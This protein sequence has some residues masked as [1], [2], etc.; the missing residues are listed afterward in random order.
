MHSPGFIAGVLGAGMV[1]LSG[2]SS[3]TVSSSG[4]MTE[5]AAAFASPPDTTR[6]KV[7]WFHGETET[8]RAGITADLEAY[9][10][11]GIGGVVYY[12]QVHNSSTPDAFEALSPDWWEMLLFSAQ[13]AERLGLTFECHVSNGYVAGGPW[14]TP[15]KGMQRLAA[16]D[17]VL[18]GGSRVEVTLPRPASTYYKDVAVLAFPSTGIWQEESRR[19]MPLI[20]SNIPSF[21]AEAVFVPGKKLVSIPVQEAGKSVYLTLD[22]GHA[23]TAR[24][25]TYQTSPRGKA[26]TSA[27]NVPGPPGETFVGTGYQELPPLGQ[28]EVSDDGIHYRPVCDI[29]PIY[30]AHLSWRQ[31]TVA[32]PTVTARYFRLNLHDWQ[33]PGIS[34]GLQL[35][36]VTLSVRACVDLWEEKAGLYSEYVAP[37][38]TPSY[39]TSEVIDPSSLVDLTSCLDAEGV[40]HWDAPA[41]EW[42]VLRFVHLPTGS[43][44]KHG[45]PNLIGLECDKMSAEAAECQWQHYFGAI[46]DT[47]ERHGI[48]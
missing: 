14:I 2:C 9:R 35:G 25:L 34:S 16:T 3:G 18:Q 38:R 31:K 48:A 45:R 8:T 13:E 11:A 30:K 19:E 6:T 24:S 39:G 21:N 15:D 4:C 47:L 20:S 37:D 36:D 40:L 43:K 10:Q 23:F 1:V 27:T 44:T 5:V 33:A 28:L 17:T 22:F 32:F 29:Q 42:V 12:D 7:W 26:T 41:G 46:A